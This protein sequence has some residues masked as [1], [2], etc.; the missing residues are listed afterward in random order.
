MFWVQN[1]KKFK[2]MQNLI[3]PL[4]FYITFEKNCFSLN[5]ILFI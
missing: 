2:I 3:A 5:A 1:A 4:R